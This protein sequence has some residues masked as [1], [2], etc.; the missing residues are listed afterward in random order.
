MY[1]KTHHGNAIGTIELTASEV[2]TLLKLFD[3][4]KSN[5]DN[6]FEVDHVIWNRTVWELNE[7]LI[8]LQKQLI[9]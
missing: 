4:I 6:K 5:P 3:V 9:G 7:N 8:E 2:R 1:H